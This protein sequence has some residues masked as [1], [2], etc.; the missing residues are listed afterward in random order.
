M[1]SKLLAKHTFI[2]ASTITLVVLFAWMLVNNSKIILTG[3]GGILIAVLFYGSASWLSKKTNVPTKFWLLVTIVAPC[4]LLGLFFMYT[5]PKV[6]TQASE[7]MER[8]PQA[9]RYLQEQISK[10]QWSGQLADNV[11]DFSSYDPKVAT[12]VDAVSSFFSSTINGLGSFIFALLLGLFLCVNPNWYINGA[13]K[14]VPPSHRTR[15]KEVLDA[16]GIALSEWLVAKIASM[17]MVGIL[18]TVGLWALGIDLALILGIIA[19]LLSF[20]PNLGPIMAFVPAAMVSMISGLNALL[21]VSM[22]YIAVQAV[23]SYVLTPVLQAKIVG[24]PPALTLFAQVILAAMVGMAGILLAAPLTIML[25]VIVNKL[26]V[27][28]LLEANHSAQNPQ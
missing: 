3:F 13:I 18:T 2:Q 19:A 27:E 20:I 1:N 12:I 16:C 6:A 4:L 8:L 22:L 21:Y 7:L 9:I 28:D 14:L 10:L 24:L 26:Y 25:M 23:E 17:V 5:G 11:K 15:I